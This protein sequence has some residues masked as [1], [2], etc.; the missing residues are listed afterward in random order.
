MREERQWQIILE[1]I[2]AFKRD[3]PLSRFLKDYYRGHKQMGS[4]DRRQASAFIYN[5]FRVCNAFAEL[6]LNSQVAL[7]NF[8]CSTAST[9]LLDYG[10]SKYVSLSIDDVIKPTEEKMELLK[11]AYP[12][13]RSEQLFPFRDLVSGRVDFAKY[14]RSF[15]EQP[16]L[17][18]R[19]RKKYHSAVLE[20][21][22][23]KN[24]SFSEHEGGAVALPNRTS[25]EELAGWK[26]GYFE[27]QDL[28]SQRSLEALNPKPG[29][30]WWDACAASGGKSLALVEKE[31]SIRLT[32]TDVRMS[33]LENL[34]KRFQ[35]AGITEYEFM[36]CDLAHAGEKIFHD[37]RLF[38]G[39]I[40]DVPCTGSGTWARTPE[41]LSMFS[42]EDLSRYNGLQKRIA[43]N[44]VKYL[45]PGGTFVYITCSVFAEENEG[46]G[47][48]ISE[49]LKLEKVNEQY[50]QCSEQ[51]ADTMFVAVFRKAV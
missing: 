50:I 42:P 34:K 25:L 41:W 45:K 29:E 39:I 6:D 37:N 30:S 46:S 23:Q 38:D 44:C 1:M 48:F 26:E 20:E 33:V 9:P 8:L 18:I 31:S 11:S 17:W 3:E 22:K 4:N 27:V 5:Y 51:Q 12:A 49:A 47:S 35:R 7:S 28:A 2:H 10:I 15:L 24:I 40:A 14:L 16:L 43:G 36:K 13:F 21:L 19:V 32:V